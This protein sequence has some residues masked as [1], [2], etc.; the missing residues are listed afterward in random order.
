L[1]QLRELDPQTNP[2]EETFSVGPVGG[3]QKIMNITHIKILLWS[4]AEAEYLDC[5]EARL[6]MKSYF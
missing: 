2:R 6:V 3:L 5:V 4:E 1:W